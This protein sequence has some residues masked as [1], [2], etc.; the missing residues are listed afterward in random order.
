MEN[1]EVIYSQ[2]LENEVYRKFLEKTKKFCLSCNLNSINCSNKED[3]V[4]QKCARSKIKQEFPNENK[5]L[6]NLQ[7]NLS[8][9][10]LDETEHKRNKYSLKLLELWTN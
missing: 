1:R 10:S 9:I 5:Y 2:I 4:C 8:Q 3:F 7:E 6:S